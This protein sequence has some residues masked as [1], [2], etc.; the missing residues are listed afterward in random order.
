LAREWFAVKRDGWA[1]SYGDK[2]IARFEASVSVDRQSRRR[3][4]RRRSCWQCLRRIE[5]RGVVET[6]TQGTADSSQFFA[7]RGHW[8]GRQ[9]SR[10]ETQGRVK[11]PDTKPSRHHRP[12]A[13][14]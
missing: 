12:Q 5:A 6:A 8:Q 11:R 2:I 14:R 3:T 9:Q 10:I 4:S 7:I 13:I 1:A